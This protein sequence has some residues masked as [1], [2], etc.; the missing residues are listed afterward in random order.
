[1]PGSVQNWV[2]SS[3]WPALPEHDCLSLHPSY[4]GSACKYL[5]RQQLQLQLS[6]LFVAAAA[7]TSRPKSRDQ[8]N[9]PKQLGEGEGPHRAG[10][11]AT[12]SPTPLEH[13]SPTPSCPGQSPPIWDF[14]SIFTNWPEQPKESRTVPAKLGSMVTLNNERCDLPTFH[15]L[16]RPFPCNHGVLLS[17]EP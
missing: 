2:H 3:P 4:T 12:P 16:A 14:A 10:F 13:S 9:P 17:R 8:S 7:A 5:T 1:M 6:S 15:C 11:A